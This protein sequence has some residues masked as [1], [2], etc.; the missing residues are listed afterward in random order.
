MKLADNKDRHKYSDEFD[1]RPDRR[2]CFGVT[3]P[4]SVKMFFHRLV[5]GKMLRIR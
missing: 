3:H 5:M 4:F 1:F 2:V